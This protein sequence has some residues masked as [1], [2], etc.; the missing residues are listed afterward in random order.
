LQRK[1]KKIEKN[2][3]ASQAS[4][5]PVAGRFLK[6]DAHSGAFLSTL[7]RRHYRRT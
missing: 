3:P 2:S 4:I 1:S 6:A 5:G 7:S